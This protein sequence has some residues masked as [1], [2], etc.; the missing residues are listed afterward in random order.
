MTFHRGVDCT[1]I[2]FFSLCLKLCFH[3]LFSVSYASLSM[4]TKMGNT[5]IYQF[6]KQPSNIFFVHKVVSWLHAAMQVLK[7]HNSS[8]L[9]ETQGCEYLLYQNIHAP[10]S[11][12]NVTYNKG[13]IWHSAT[14]VH[15]R[16]SRNHIQ[17]V[18]DHSLAHTAVVNTPPP[19]RIKKESSWI[20]Q[21]NKH[22]T[23]NIDCDI[24]GSGNNP[25]PPLT[26]K[27]DGL[28]NNTYYIA[29]GY[30]AKRHTWQ[31]DM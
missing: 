6:T 26:M 20:T 18:G 21:E 10:T 24:I 25:P 8:L 31:V 19:Q 11:R 5:D 3:L 22:T 13:H 30:L 15:I 14:P 1:R 28:R 9:Q 7:R 12:W 16:Q 23:E 29:S 27:V 2:F 17:Y 4:E